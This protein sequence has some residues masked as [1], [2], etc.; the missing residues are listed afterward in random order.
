MRRL[1]DSEQTVQKL[2][3]ALF[4]LLREKEYN[5]ISISEIA[6]NT[7]ISRTSFYLFFDSKDEVFA[8]LCDSLSEQWFTDFFDANYAKDR[9]TEEKLFMEFIVWFE[10]RKPAFQN[11]FLARSEK[12]DDVSLL[13]KSVEKRMIERGR[14]ILHSDAMVQ[15]FCLFSKIYSASLLAMLQWWIS[16]GSAFT[17]ED[18]HELL[19]RLRY[20]GF[21]SIIEEK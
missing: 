17:V 8:E 6:A 16:D 13:A 21:Y 11:I 5:D 4:D 14:L 15:R 10:Q 2:K 1:H 3:R 18:F 20:R 19:D 9:D 7:G 12:F